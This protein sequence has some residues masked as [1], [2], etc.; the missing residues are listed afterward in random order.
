[1]S[2]TSVLLVGAAGETGGSI[3]NGLLDDG[4]FD[5]IAL[6]RPISVHKPAIRKLEER[7]VKIRKCDLKAPEEHLIEALADIEVVISCVGPAEQQDQIPLARAAKKV[8]VKRFIPCGFITVAP[9]GGVMWLRDEKEIVYNQIRQMWLPYTIVDVGWW[10]QLSYPRLLS[11]RVDY[12]MTS[13]ND[14]IIGDGNMPT[15]L[16]DLRD[17]GRYMAMIISDERTLNKK[18]LAYNLVSTQ[19]EIYNL[20]EE[21]S[22]EKVDRNYVPEET[23]NSR[24]LAA[25][26][27]SETYPFDPIKFIPR[28][29]AEYQYSWGIRGDNNPEYAKYLGYHLTTELYPDFKPTDFKEYLESVI[30]GTAKGVYQDRVISRKHQRHFPRTE[31]SDSLYTRIFPRTES[32][33]SLMSR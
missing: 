27:A 22:E 3:A 32:S 19:N 21:I 13:G 31:S 28:Y 29:L 18:I 8:G 26:Q 11:G 6:V 16:T 25:R 30:R 2:K 24:V 15:A 14:E 5:V 1:M 7:G 12:A 10:Y 23:I 17:I 4:R 9:P 33:D 20:L